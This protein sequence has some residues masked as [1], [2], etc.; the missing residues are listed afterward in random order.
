M[1]DCTDWHS[2][3]WGCH[4]FVKYLNQSNSSVTL[5]CYFNLSSTKGPWKQKPR[6]KQILHIAKL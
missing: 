1:E 6:Q 2:R 4:E 3:L 5:E